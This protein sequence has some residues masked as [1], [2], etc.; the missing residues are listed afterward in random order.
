MS[1]WLAFGIVLGGVAC[2]HYHPLAAFTDPDDERDRRIDE[3]ACY[4]A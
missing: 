4:G 3:E 2:E 1:P